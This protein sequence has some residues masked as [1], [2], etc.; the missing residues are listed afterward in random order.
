[1]GKFIFLLIILI[2]LSLYLIYQNYKSEKN[3][4]KTFLQ[5]AILIFLVSETIF[6]R[7]T[8]I[9][10]P[11]LILHI[12]ALIAAW[13]NFFAILMNKTRFYWLIFLPILTT[14]IFFF[15]A[16]FVIEFD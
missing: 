9:Y 5:I 4:K 1:M 8:I 10:L 15:S 13:G 14:L 2:I 6:S 3:F 12:L 16:I 11:I 7:Y